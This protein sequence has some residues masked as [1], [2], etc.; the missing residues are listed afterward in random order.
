MR[1]NE[2]NES[3]KLP[4]KNK[5]GNNKVGPKNDYYDKF[6]KPRLDKVTEWKIDGLSNKQIAKNLGIVQSTFYEY[7]SKH[8][9]LSEAVEKGKVSAIAELENAAFKS[10]TG[11]KVSEK[12]VEQDADGKT[13][14]TVTEKYIPP[15]PAQNIFMLKNLMPK[16][17]KDKIETEHNVNINFNKLDNL[18]NEQLL[19]LVKTVDIPTSDYS[20]E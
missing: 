20:I 14:V 9:E 5:D 11:H 13:K 6:V 19:E 15:N 18:T 2:S 10:A 4:A 12:K 8:E 17:Y 16:K 3:N 1:G 7:M